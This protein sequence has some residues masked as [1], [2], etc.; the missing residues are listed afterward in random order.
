MAVEFKTI[1]RQ[2]GG[3]PKVPN[4]YPCRM[5]VAGGACGAAKGPLVLLAGDPRPAPVCPG[6]FLPVL[7]RAQS[8]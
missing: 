4:W 6:C 1:Q 7:P 3:L 8:L 5:P 2:V